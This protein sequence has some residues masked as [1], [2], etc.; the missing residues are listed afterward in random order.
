MANLYSFCSDNC[1]NSGA[2]KLVPVNNSNPSKKSGNHISTDSLVGTANG[3]IDVVN[4]F[5]WTTS[6]KGQSSRQEV[7]GIQ[8]RE[9]KLRTNS[10]IAAAA[11]YL[12]SGASSAGTI[13]NRASTTVQG[14]APGLQAAA[15]TFF[16]N[17]ISSPGVQT[18]G[19]V[20]GSIIQQVL[21]SASTLTTGITDINQIVGQNIEGLNSSLLQA[22]EGLYITED[23]K[24]S[25]YLPYFSNRLTESANMFS[26]DE[27]AFANSMI[28]NAVGA[29]RGAAESLAVFANFKEPGIYIERPKFFNFADNGDQIQID[30]PLI[31]TGNSTYE[32]VRLNWQLIYLLTY[33]N[34][35]N[36]RSRE[37]IDP[38]SIYEV[39]IPGVKYIP[40]A[41]MSRIQVDYLGARRQMQIDVPTQNGNSTIFTI[42]PD[43]YEVKLT[44]TGLVPESKNFMAAMLAEKQ[45]DLVEVVN[46]NTFN[47]FGEAYNVFTNNY[48]APNP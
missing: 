42:I 30:F 22:Y 31:N 4:D 40:F 20:A 17:I 9:K 24:F 12:M 5:Y 33:Q 6:P 16:S 7:P 28:S 46:Y 1:D 29:I 43:A 36:R 27:G 48:N 35:P 13:L 15:T 39:S 23:T 8:L 11:Y 32:D 21:N 45:G 18:A 26:E 2:P 38:S 25:Y 44:L 19:N 10:V 47:P 37:L 3:L 34:R 41:Y 14:V